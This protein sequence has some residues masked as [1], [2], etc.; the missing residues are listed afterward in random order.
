MELA[1]V[2]PACTAACLAAA[3]PAHAHAQITGDDI[4]VSGKSVGVCTECALVV[5][6]GTSILTGPP[7]TIGPLLN[8]IGTCGV[9]A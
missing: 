7:S 6:T 1:V 4:K 8:A 9:C 5:D 3:A 2:S